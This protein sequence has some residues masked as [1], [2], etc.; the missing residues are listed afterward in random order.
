MDIEIDRIAETFNSVEIY[1]EK[2][3][4]YRSNESVEN[5]TEV[6]GNSKSMDTVSMYSTRSHE[7]ARPALRK[8]LQASLDDMLVRKLKP[9]NLLSKTKHILTGREREKKLEA[10]SRALSAS[11]GDVAGAGGAPLPAAASEPDLRQISP[12]PLNLFL[13]PPPHCKNTHKSHKPIYHHHHTTLTRFKLNQSSSSEQHNRTP[14]YQ[15][16]D[17]TSNII[18][19]AL[20]GLPKSTDAYLLPSSFTL[21]RVVVVML[22]SIDSCATAAVA[23]RRQVARCLAEWEQS[24]ILECVTDLMRSVHRV[25]ERP[26]DLLPSTFPCTT[27]RSMESSLRVMCPKNLRIRICTVDDNLQIPNDD[28]QI[29]RSF[30]KVQ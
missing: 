17:T 16:L 9:L 1:E 3:S 28:F 8:H 4:E 14:C 5:M 23:T 24:F 19:N 27:S 10:R 30:S 25:G 7:E 20:K 2:L 21:D 15:M 29:T 6:S 12:A 22:W 26:R 11:A 18:S 13:P